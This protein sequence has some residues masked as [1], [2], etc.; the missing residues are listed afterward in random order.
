MSKKQNREQQILDFINEFSI[1]NGYPPSVREICAG[2]GLSSPSSVH[3]YLKR[4][5]EKGLL[6]KGESK[7]RALRLVETKA[8]QMCEPIAEYLSVPVIGQVAAGSPILAEENI[9]DTYPLPMVFAKN[10]NVFMLRVRGESMINAGILDG[11]Y[12]V[13]TQQETALNG[14]IVVALLGD[15]ATVKTFYKENG[16]IRLQPE[17]DTMEPIIVKDLKIIGK[18]S[19]VFRIY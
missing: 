1:S 5:E 11:D 13:V 16:Y 18:V 4:L 3:D 17:N 12:V 2:V 14:D 7:T 9:I 6:I 8:E 19:G 15:S 10:K